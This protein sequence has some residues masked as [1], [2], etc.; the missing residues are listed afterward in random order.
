MP[1][2]AEGLRVVL[3]LT[4][5]RELLPPAAQEMSDAELERLRGQFYRLAQTAFEVG[6]DRRG[7]SMT[8]NSTLDTDD[9][10]AYDRGG[11]E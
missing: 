1:S 10:R 3:S 11:Q 9:R 8:T 6:A 7:R 4:R 5:C 2:S